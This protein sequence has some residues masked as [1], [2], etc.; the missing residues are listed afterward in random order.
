MAKVGAAVVPG[1]ETLPGIG[2]NISETCFLRIYDNLKKGLF[3]CLFLIPCNIGL[4]YLFGLFSGYVGRDCGCP[5][6]LFGGFSVYTQ[7]IGYLG[8]NGGDA[9]VDKSGALAYAH[10]LKVCE[11]ADFLE[12]GFVYLKVFLFAVVLAVYGGEDNHHHPHIVLEGAVKAHPVHK[13]FRFPGRAGAVGPDE[14]Y[15]L[16]MGKAAGV[17]CR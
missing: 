3:L 9:L 6:N 5:L 12:E 10:N 16:H 8:C 13:G 17:I 4:G 14:P 2:H 7:D 15:G 11:N 1:K